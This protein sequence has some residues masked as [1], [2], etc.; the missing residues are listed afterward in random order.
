MYWFEL[1][2][3]VFHPFPECE[4][5]ENHQDFFYTF[6]GSWTRK[7]TRNLSSLIYQ[8]RCADRNLGKSLLTCRMG[9]Q[10]MVQWLVRITPPFKM[11]AMK[12]TAI[13][14]PGSNPTRSLGDPLITMV[15]NHVSKQ[16]APFFRPI[17][18]PC[19]QREPKPTR[20]TFH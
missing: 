18:F 17:F 15:I 19:E 5:S 2:C 4:T 6:L 12:Q 8:L 9:S 3:F 16:L 11:S 13:W 10:W 1:G 14:F 7:Q 20:T